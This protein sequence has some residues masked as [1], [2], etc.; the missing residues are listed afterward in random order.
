MSETAAIIGA[1]ASTLGPA[2]LG[3]AWLWR[4]VEKGFKELK[5]ELAECKKREMKAARQQ[6]HD[7]VRNAKQLIV[8]ELLWQVASR[9]KS[10]TPVVARCKEHLDDLK[11]YDDEKR[12]EDEQ[13]LVR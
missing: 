12:T 13:D 9:S 1:I 3:I 8:I 4:R 6:R 5:D 7:S 11:R 10:A 2:G